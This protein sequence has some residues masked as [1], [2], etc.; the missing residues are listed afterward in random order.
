MD[1]G[2]ER[3]E[4]DVKFVRV[5]RGSQ[6]C[7]GARIFEDTRSLGPRVISCYPLQNIHTRYKYHTVS[8]G[9]AERLQ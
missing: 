6:G 2:R 4:V 9:G 1:G 5:G 8:G 7:T 3:G